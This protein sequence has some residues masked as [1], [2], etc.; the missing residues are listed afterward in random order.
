[1]TPENKQLV[2]DSWA[3]VLPIKETAAELFYGRLFEVYPEVKPMFKGDMKEQ[4]RK[5]MAMLNTA[6]NGLDNL[7]PLLEPLKKMG[8]AHKGYGVS[9][10]DYGKV[11]DAFLWTLGQGL[12]DDFTDDVKNAWVETYTAV[13]NVM[14]EGAEYDTS[15]ESAA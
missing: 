12:G 9:A 6:V 10:D 14:I 8:A 2:K 4:G 1:M 15:E 11:A 7:E 5:L 3:K 13:A